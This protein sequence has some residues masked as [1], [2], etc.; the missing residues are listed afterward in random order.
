MGLTP[1]RLHRC[2]IAFLVGCLLGQLTA[3]FA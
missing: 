1:L 3:C 2:V